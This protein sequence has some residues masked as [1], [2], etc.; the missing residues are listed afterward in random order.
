MRPRDMLL[1]SSDFLQ[2]LGSLKSLCVPCNFTSPTTDLAGL[3]SLSTKPLS[4]HLSFLV[5]AQGLGP[6]DRDFPSTQDAVTRDS[7]YPND[8]GETSLV[9]RSLE[10][11]E[12]ARI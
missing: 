8:A 1:I 11:S 2:C 10:V 4:S 7:R 9:K 12:S 6:R 3:E 5:A